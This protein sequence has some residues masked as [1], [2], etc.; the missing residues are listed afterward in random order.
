MSPGVNY[1]EEETG[2]AQGQKQKSF[3][4]AFPELLEASG[5]FR[6]VHAVT[7]YTNTPLSKRGALEFLW[8]L[9][10]SD[11]D[12]SSGVPAGAVSRGYKHVQVL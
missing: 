8:P 6:K 5:D 2:K 3:G 4:L 11:S 9:P 7:I 1:Q 10:G 12:R